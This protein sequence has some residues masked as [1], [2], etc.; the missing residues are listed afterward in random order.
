M[1]YFCWLGTKNDSSGA[2]KPHSLYMNRCIYDPRTKGCGIIPLMLKRSDSHSSR[3]GRHETAAAPAPHTPKTTPFAQ[4]RAGGGARGFGPQGGARNATTPGTIQGSWGPGPSGS[5]GRR[6][7]TK[8]LVLVVAALLALI[9]LTTALQSC[10]EPHARWDWNNLVNENGRMAYYEDGQKTSTVGVDVSSLQGEI[11]WH[12]VREDGVDF[13]MIRCGRRGYTEG[14]I[15]ADDAFQQ[16]VS[17]ATA[18]GLPFGVYFFSQALN[19]QE[20]LEEAEYVL[21]QISGTG[22]RY[23]VV[24][25]QEPIADAQGRANDL[26][27]EQL[28]ANARAFCECIAD[29]GYQP[30]VYGNQHDLAR[31]NVS[32]L[33]YPIWYA[34]YTDGHPTGDFD[35]VMWQYTNKGSVNG[36]SGN[37]DLN[38]LFENSA[39]V[40][41]E[42]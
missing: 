15:H 31:M 2:S 37:V 23:P 42:R 12:A 1:S 29:A 38:I 14:Q 22:V 26:S 20:A 40:S 25:D 10:S 18:A 21:D 9:A 32:D 13:A 5:P 27:A 4:S 28:T 34:E 24:F 39:W 16:N 36:I 3:H 19:E 17:G 30:M 6:F 7:P 8:A 33:G 11:D 41:R 35:F